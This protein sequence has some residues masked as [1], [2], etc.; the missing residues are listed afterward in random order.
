ME[1]KA[2]REGYGKGLEEISKDERVIALDA[3]LSGSTK[4]NV[5]CKISPERF[6]NVGIAE[7]DLV[8]MAAGLA[9][10]GKIPFASTFAVFATARAHDQV[11]VS[12][13]YANLNVRIVGS[14]AGLLTGEDGPTHQ[15][16]SDIATMRSIPNISVIHPADYIEAKQAT[17]YLLKHKGPVY[18]RLGRS[19]LPIINKED[20]KFEFGKAIIL[21]KGSDVTII[22]TGPL[23]HEALSA[24]EELKK[25]NISAEII[26]IHTIKPIDK[27]TIIE[28]AKKTKAVV[29]AEDH[30]II[31][32]L[33]SAVSEVLSEN[34]PTPIEM[35]GVKDTF[36]ES[37]KPM[38]LY[39][40]YGLTSKH[41][42]K[43]VKKVL[44][45]K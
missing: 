2:T 12:V 24:H 13:A 26:N 41:I 14:H 21:K 9:L 16:I 28:S 40:K 8:G 45:R 34:Q 22:A 29:T 6:I 33:G 11:R 20:Y 5:M 43:A 27:K 19:K 3:D 7:Q 39:E 17:K 42:I 31:G 18:L 37:G 44:K 30:N 36:A 35:I 32:G 15:A 10:S 4:S 25:Q 23:V 38:E 1:N